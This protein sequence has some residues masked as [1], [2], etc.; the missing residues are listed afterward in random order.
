MLDPT[1]Q[2]FLRHLHRGG[3][4]A[5]WWTADVAASGAQGRP[6]TRSYWWPTSRTPIPLPTAPQR[7]VYFGVHPCRSRR[8]DRQ[9]ATIAT[10]AVINCLYAEFDLEPEGDRAALLAHIEALTPA[11]SAIIDSGGGYHAYWLLAEPLLLA[12]DTSRERARNAQYAWVAWTGGDDASKDLARVLRV[13]GTTNCKPKYGPNFPTVRFVRA[14]LDRTYTLE[15]LEAVAAIYLRTPKPV[16]C[17]REH[18]AV[19]AGLDDLSRAREALDRLSVSRCDDYDDWL[20]VGMALHA[21]LGTSGLSLWDSWSQRS[22]KY[23][24]GACEAKWRGFGQRPN[25]YTL[26]SLFYWA[27]EDSPPRIK[28]HPSPASRPSAPSEAAADLSAEDAGETAAAPPSVLNLTDLGNAQRLVARH[29]ADLRYVQEWGWMVWDGRRWD[30]DRT[31]EV[32]RRAKETAVSIAGEAEGLADPKLQ[33]KVLAW[34]R[35]SQSRARLEAMVAL[36]QS[37][38]TI[39]ARTDAFDAHDWLLNCRNGTLDLKDGALRP[40]RREDLLTRLVDV[41]YDAAAACPT[42][43]QFLDRVMDGNDDLIAYLRRTIGYALTGDTGEQAMF[44]LY[45]TGANGKST[46]LEVVRAL[47]GDY[48]RQTDPTTFLARQNSDRIPNDIARLAGARFVSGIE[49]EEGRRL[50]EVLIKQ[51]ISG[52]TLTARFLNRE[53]FEFRARFKLFLAANHKPVI[54]GTDE[55]IWRRIRLIPFT[56]TIPKPERDRTLLARLLDELPGILAWAVRGCLDWG[57]RGLAD[58]PEVLAATE[59]YRSEMDVVGAFLDERCVRAPSARVECAALYAAYSR[60]CEEMGEFAIS[61][62]RFGQKIEERGFARVRSTNGRWYRVG[63]GLRDDHH[64][65]GPHGPPTAPAPEGN[66]A[67]SVPADEIDGPEY[68]E[69]AGSTD[70]PAPTPPLDQLQLPEGEPEGVGGVNWP[71]VQRLLAIGDATAL[72]ALRTHCALCRVPVEHVIAL[73]QPPPTAADGLAATTR[74]EVHGDVTADTA[75]G[76]DHP[77]EQGSTP[78]AAPGAR[79][80]GGPP[81]ESEPVG[82]LRAA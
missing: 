13:P 55:G 50:S 20:H 21:G 15:Q 43:E 3:R 79:G 40:H 74:N 24:P 80:G 78:G 6:A 32:M 68:S 73:S 41:E 44:L 19:F 66:T 28:I 7:N 70:E 49:V 48:G 25:G 23:E 45:G 52:D 72:E 30:L 60:W 35:A 62:R 9:R 46:F 59:S 51:V 38:P 75:R 34:A 14:D 29:G 4:W 36:A 18:Q 58:P 64:P 76:A 26:A 54:K 31:G 10:V 77:G 65:D 37:E 42:W 22:A 27:D 12:D 1:F 16:A 57:A 5:Y 81:P 67:A 82:R 8:G 47:V 2:A 11:P 33:A 69:D 17:V 71:Y 56:V 61:Q 63:I 39:P 53:F